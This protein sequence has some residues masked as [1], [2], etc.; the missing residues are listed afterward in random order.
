MIY[1]AESL[2]PSSSENHLKSQEE[3][4]LLHMRELIHITYPD[5][6][7]GQFSFFTSENKLGPIIICDN[8][9]QKVSHMTGNGCL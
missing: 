6:S 4:N 8:C 1:R 9:P 7:G 3:V 2:F 5:V